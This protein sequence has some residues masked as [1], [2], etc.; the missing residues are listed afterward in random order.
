MPT[1]LIPRLVLGAALALAAG[2]VACDA[3]D[4]DDPGSTPSSNLITIEPGVGGQD[5]SLGVRVAASWSAFDFEGS[6]LDFGE[7]ITVD[8]LLV[9]DAWNIEADITIAPDAALGA[10]DVVVESAGY[11]RTIEEGFTVIEESF[12]ISPEVGMLGET[13]EVEFVGKNTAW[14]GGVTWPSFGDGVH[15]MDFTVI[16]D[17]LATASISVAGDTYAGPRD[18][19]METGA[20]VV[21]LYDGF[22]VDR[23]GLAASWDPAVIDQGETVDFEIEARGTNFVAGETELVI[24]DGGEEINDYA[25]DR[26]VVVDATHLYGE[27]TLSNA[28][29]IGWRDVLITTGSEGVVIPDAF[30]VMEGELDL[31]EVAVYI[32]FNITRGIDNSSC[33]VAENVFAMVWF[34]IP[35]D[36]PC[37]G[38]GAMGSGPQPYDVNGVFAYPEGGGGGG[39]DCPTPT[40]VPAGDYVWLESDYNT[41]TLDRVE[42]TTS[43]MVYYYGFDLSAQDYGAGYWYDLH[44]QGEDGG[45]PEYL[46]ENVQPTVPADWELTSPAL[47]QDYTHNRA[48]D[49]TYTWTPA[50]TYPDA[51]FVTGIPGTLEATGTGGFLGCV[52]WDDGEHSYLASEMSQ[53][54]AAPAEPYFYSYIEG[55]DFGL[56]DSIYQSNPTESY[57]YLSAYMV[58]E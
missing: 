32:A 8:E 16:T 23:A 46:V 55:P 48:Q 30:E 45:L 44:P 35:L 31:S 52:P 34:Y 53:L 5:T 41:V 39:D 22:Q 58:L 27:I 2:L 9:L 3:T 4:S 33:Q 37:G 50:E 28:A 20:A 51:M 26:L 42:D 11:T 13:L 17:Q 25:I 10:R 24:L 19:L 54:V 29:R 40:S 18:V 15:I 57:I 36:P 56:P 49:F 14:Q 43:G 7:G 21:V 12:S 47:C 6:S 1:R 38:G